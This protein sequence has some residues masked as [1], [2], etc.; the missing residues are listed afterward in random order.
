MDLNRIVG[1]SLRVGVLVSAVLTLL[2]LS[3][4]A[5]GGF[6][7]ASIP[8]VLSVGV[9]LRLAFSGD[10]TGIVYLGVIVLIATPIFRIAISS[11]YFAAERD[12]AYAGITILVLGM[13]LFALYSGAAG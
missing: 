6:G 5:V 7:S 4:W 11:I 8:G 9:I 10:L 13:L 1:Q 12:R 3:L 2:G